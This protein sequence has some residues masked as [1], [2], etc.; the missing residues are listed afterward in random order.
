M[1]TVTGALK[2]VTLYIMA[3][4]PQ[5]YCPESV[6]AEA[7]VGPMAQ[8]ECLAFMGLDSTKGEDYLAKLPEEEYVYNCR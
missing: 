1:L 7:W 4:N 5:G 2:V 3:C 8:E 6:D